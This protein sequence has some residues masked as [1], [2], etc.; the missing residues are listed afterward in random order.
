MHR[1]MQGRNSR[2][3]RV[4]RVYAVVEEQHADL[5]ERRA[6]EPMRMRHERGECAVKLWAVPMALSDRKHQRRQSLEWLDDA[7]RKSVDFA[8][9]QPRGQVSA[10]RD[11][12]PGAVEIG[13]L[14]REMQRRR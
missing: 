14:D 5:L 8:D 4:V 12:S 9:R 7:D 2:A 6:R 3:I 10:G 13:L 11:E 1:V